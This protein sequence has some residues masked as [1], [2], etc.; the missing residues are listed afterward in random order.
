LPA[1]AEVTVLRIVQEALV[2]VQ[3]HAHAS[4]AVVRLERQGGWFLARVTDDGK[5]LLPSAN[6]GASAGTG[7]LSMRQRS[8]LLG[9][10][11]SLDNQPGGGTN[12]LAR[13]PARD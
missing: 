6:G 2:N 3:K 10:T 11:L 1:A 9:G 4:R 5:G 12:L 7:L 13:I 8:E